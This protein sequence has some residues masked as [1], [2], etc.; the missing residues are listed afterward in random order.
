MRSASELVSCLLLL[1]GAVTA[2]TGQ[3]THYERLLPQWLTGIIAVSGFLLLTFVGFLVKKFWCEESN[4][5]NA[6]MESVRDNEY[7]ESNPYVG[8]LDN[9][10]PSTGMEKENNYETRLDILR[11][12]D[13]SNIYESCIPDSSQDKSTAM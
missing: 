4:G 13:G 7:V 10:R 12:R 3:P 11:S 5:R 9:I 1:V 6:S 2:Q 8:N